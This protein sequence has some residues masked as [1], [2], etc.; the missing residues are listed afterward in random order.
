MRLIDWQHD[1]FHTQP[2]DDGPPMDWEQLH[3]ES[4]EQELRRD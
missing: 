4:I 1:G 3:D 2:W